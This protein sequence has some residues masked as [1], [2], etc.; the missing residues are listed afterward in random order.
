[1]PTRDKFVET[2]DAWLRADD[3]HRD[4]MAAVSGGTWSPA[5]FYGRDEGC[6]VT[7]GY[8]VRDPN[9][10]SLFGRYVY[11]DFCAGQLRRSRRRR[12]GRRGS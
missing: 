5:L 12:S 1:M 9:L 11:G 6:S 2:Y 8:V 3:Q 4:Q 10:T 7:G